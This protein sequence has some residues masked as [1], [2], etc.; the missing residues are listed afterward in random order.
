MYESH[1]T[2]TYKH[3]SKK[4]QRKK[5]IIIP[6][7]MVII[8]QNNSRAYLKHALFRIKNYRL[9]SVIVSAKKIRQNAVPIRPY[10]EPLQPN[11]S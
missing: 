11:N 8:G 7:P 2:Y 5:Q 1:D 9:L 4:K 3:M 10:P 6:E